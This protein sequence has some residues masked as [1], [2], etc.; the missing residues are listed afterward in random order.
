M[1]RPLDMEKIAR[2][3]RAKRRGRVAA[4]G[5]YLGSLELAADVRA[6]FR[7]PT[8]GG[9]ATDPA[10][11]EQRL[12]RLR[13]ATLTKL[14]ALARRLRQE[15]DLAIEPMQLAALLLERATVVFER[16]HAEDLLRRRSR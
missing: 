8:R 12:V 16:H 4:R 1:K 15:D 7:T 6:R 11:T 3:L 2:G 9:R 10:W 5:G 13:P 14:E